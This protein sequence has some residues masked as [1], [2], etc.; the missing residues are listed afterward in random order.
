MD[1]QTGRRIVKVTN[2]ALVQVLKATVARLRKLE[3]ELSELE[4]ALEDEREELEQYSDDIDDC[5]DRLDDIDEFVREISKG[6]VRSVSDVAGALQEM[7]EER[8]EER[9]LVDVLVET[10]REHE[11]QLRDLQTQTAA[12]KREQMLLR[13]T[14]LEI[15]GLF[16]RNGVMELVRRRLA[17]RSRKLL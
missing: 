17:V 14:R 1:K 16:R 15:F 8:E 11:Q 3:A 7:A 5:Y 10:R 2:F 4:L 13:K 12:L 9:N 6:N